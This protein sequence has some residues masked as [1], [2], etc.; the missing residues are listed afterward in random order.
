ML[1]AVQRGGKRAFGTLHSLV[2]RP[3]PWC[4]ELRIAEDKPEGLIGAPG[5]TRRYA[6]PRAVLFPAAGPWRK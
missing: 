2:F 3:E 6:I 1:A 5:S 4:F